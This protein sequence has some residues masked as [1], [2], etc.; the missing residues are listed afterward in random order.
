MQQL[1]MLKTTFEIFFNMA[2]LI[3]I[4]KVYLAFVSGCWM[5]YS[6]L[7]LMVNMM[8]Q[9]IKII[10]VIFIVLFQLFL[11]ENSL[12]LMLERETET[13]RCWLE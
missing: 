5:L 1:T 13:D 10:D 3:L 6:K 4:V 7:L 11:L 8:F 12:V 9:P 2:K